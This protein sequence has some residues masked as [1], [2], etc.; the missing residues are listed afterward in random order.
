MLLAGSAPAPADG[1][2]VQGSGDAV[3]NVGR[4]VARASGLPL[5]IT[6]GGA[7]GHYQGITARGEAA[8]LDLGVLGIL[9]TTSTGGCGAG[10]APLTPDQLPKRTVAD[11][12]TGAAS[13]SKDVAGNGPVGAGREEA[14]ARPGALGQAAYTSAA[15]GLGELL[16]LGEGRSSGTAE[17]VDGQERR[18]QAQVQF[19]NLDVAG[20]LVALRGLRWTAEQRT[21]AGGL[22]LGAEGTF[23]LDA[24]TVA[25]IP[26]PTATPLELAT[27]FGAANEVIAPLGLRLEPPRVTKT[28]GDREVRVTPLKL[29]LGDGTVAK[30]LLGPLMSE[31]QP[32]R[33]ALLEAMKGFG[34]GDCN[35][36]AAGGLSFTFVDVVAA[37][38]GGNG[39]IDLELGGVLATTEGIDYGDPFGVTPPGLPAVPPLVVPSVRPLPAVPSVTIEEPGQPWPGSDSEVAAPV[40]APPAPVETAAPAAPPA[41]EP[42]AVLPATR[43]CESTSRGRVSGCSRG[44]PLPASAAALAAAVLLFGGDWWRTR[45]RS[46]ERGQP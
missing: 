41:A 9:L 18:A 20:G 23:G 44:A 22:V 4:L 24:M 27:A 1:P 15:L 40:A 6:F 11:S 12:R 3:A 2:F 35:L 8:T 5:A 39:G 31:T 33:E 37:A 43:R 36:G 17:L 28:T 38:L 45:R 13:A 25:G 29:V 46:I 32:V 42:V 16:A 21:G 7:L 34:N 10:R 26:L 19:G 30:P 14:S